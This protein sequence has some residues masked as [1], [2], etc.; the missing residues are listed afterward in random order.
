[1][2]LRSDLEFGL[3]CFFILV[4]IAFMGFIVTALIIRTGVAQFFA[5]TGVIVAIGSAVL[6]LIYLL[7]FIPSIVEEIKYYYRNKKYFKACKAEKEQ[8]ARH[9]EKM[10]TVRLSLGG[11]TSSIP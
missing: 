10:K 3:G 5:Y 9:A 2:R 6:L 1:M 11:D 8:L 4:G 7:S